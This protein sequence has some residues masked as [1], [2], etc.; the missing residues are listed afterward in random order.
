MI[1]FIVATPSPTRF[2]VL[3]LSRDP[4]ECKVITKAWILTYGTTGIPL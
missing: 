1:S 4:D 3:L 2:R